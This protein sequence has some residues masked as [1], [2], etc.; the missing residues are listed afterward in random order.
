MKRIFISSVVAIILALAS[1]SQVAFAADAQQVAPATPDESITLS[2]V[3]TRFAIDAGQ[4]RAG[5]MTI[6][7]DGKSDYDFIVYARPYWVANDSY[8]PVFTKG[9]KQ[10][11]AYQWVRLPQTKFHAKSGETVKVPYTID[12]PATA[13][14]GGH[15]GVIF[16]ETQPS[17]T[18]EQGNS[19]ERKK[20]VGMI[21]YAS[22]NGQTINKGEIVGNQVQFWQTQPPMKATATARNE[23]N[24][25]F[26]DKVTFA[27]KDM[28]GNPKYVITKE[29]PVLPQTT[30]S[31]GLEWPQSPWFGLFKVE[32]QQ[33]FL[34]KELTS[35]HYVLMM[36]RL[37]PVLLIA[38]LVIGGGV[39]LL[40]RKKRKA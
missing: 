20:R 29:Y 8:D 25:D 22:V 35:T 1:V 7:N 18:G 33:Q 5:E 9:S 17:N 12:V 16:A 3:S 34:D 24:V 2:P 31:I 36:P 19:V 23:G 27:V 39:A 15:Y 10:S 6:V 21:I 11:D 26:V 32:I 28:F 40:H 13:A 4:Q 30:R 38:L 14:P 37:L